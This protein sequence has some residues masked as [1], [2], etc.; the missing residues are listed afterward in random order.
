MEN[1]RLQAQLKMVLISSYQSAA[2]KIL[3]DGSGV[4]DMYRLDN[5]NNQSNFLNAFMAEFASYASK[6]E[7][8]LPKTKPFSALSKKI[9]EAV[10]VELARKGRQFTYKSFNDSCTDLILGL[11]S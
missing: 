1:A 11:M 4:I 5:E 6:I 9:K 2:E 3:M 8:H 7:K 10:R